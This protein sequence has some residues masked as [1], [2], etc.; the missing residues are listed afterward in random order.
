MVPET[1][2]PGRPGIL[3]SR[4]IFR[5]V[6]PLMKASLFKHDRGNF[7]RNG[8]RQKEIRLPQRAMDRVWTNG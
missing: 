8:V 4:S 6:T 7:G 3:A 1:A 5:V 2:D